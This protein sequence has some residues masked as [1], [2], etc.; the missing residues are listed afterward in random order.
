[1]SDGDDWKDYPRDVDITR[2]STGLM[3]SVT[4]RLKLERLKLNWKNY[5]IVQLINPLF[6]ELKPQRIRP[7]YDYLRRYNRHMIMGAF[8]MDYY[9]VSTCLDCTTFR[10]SDFNFGDHQRREE[11]YNQA[12][13]R[14]WMGD[15]RRLLN[16]YIADDCD[17][18]VT[19]LCEYDM[20]YRPQYPSK[21]TFIPF[22]I[23]EKEKGKEDHHHL[24]NE[25]RPVRIFIG[26]Q[27]TRSAYKGTDIMLRALER[28][29]AEYPD[30]LEIMKVESV[31]FD[32]YKRLMDSCDV[33]V[34]QLYSYTPAM[35]ALQAMSQGLVV[36][37]GGEPEN[38]EILGERV[39]HPIV[40]VLPNE[41]DCYEKMQHLILNPHLIRAMQLDSMEYIRKHHSL[42]RVAKAYD[43]L[44]EKL[45]KT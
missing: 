28:L 44:Y 12:F 31:P 3:D 27:R 6:L 40:N 7:F 13:I 20:C 42:E 16:M 4:Y 45:M 19:G 29:K 33:I 25:G 34:D 5:D 17:A 9:Y 18:I 38:Y 11:S 36:V 8:G 32:E 15:D 10:Y 14:D 39:L 1:V 22:P 21:T 35:N 41:E 2:K 30:K 43:A 26:I 37:G 23:E 24:Y